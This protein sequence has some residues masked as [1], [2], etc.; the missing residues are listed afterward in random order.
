MLGEA[1]SEV[2]EYQETRN[3][4]SVITEEEPSNGRSNTQEESLGT[5][6]GAI[7]LEGPKQRVRHIVSFGFQQSA[8]NAEGKSAHF[9]PNMVFSGARRHD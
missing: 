4:T 3:L 2:G 6:I 8:E 1:V 9:L 7:N 5:A